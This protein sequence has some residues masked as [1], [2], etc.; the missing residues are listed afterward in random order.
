M[1]G[2]RP[3][4][5]LQQSIL[6]TPILQLASRIMNIPYTHN[7]RNIELESLA[8]EILSYSLQ[9]FVY[10]SN[11]TNLP[12]AITKSEFQRLQHAKEVLLQQMDNPPSLLELSRIIGMNDFKLKHHFKAV[13]GTTVFGYLRDIRM[14]KAILLLQDGMTSVSMAAAHVGY[15]NA[16]YFA[17]AFRKRYGM[18]PSEFLHYAN[19]IR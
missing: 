10:D 12:A 2:S 13:F 4:L 6:D 19:N 1:I 14:E 17:S 9:I 5:Q 18:N 7:I 3:L 11:R 15:T 16:S 8:L